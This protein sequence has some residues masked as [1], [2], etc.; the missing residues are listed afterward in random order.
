MLFK[1]SKPTL[2]K[3]SLIIALFQLVKTTLVKEFSVT[4]LFQNITYVG[5]NFVDHCAFAKSLPEK[6]QA[7]DMYGFDNAFSSTLVKR[8]SIFVLFQFVKP[9]LINCAFAVSL[10]DKKSQQLICMGLTTS[11]LVKKTLIIVFFH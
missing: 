11:T 9:S 2:V 8:T 4:V 1:L 6:K 7:V 5:Q 3:E 10:P